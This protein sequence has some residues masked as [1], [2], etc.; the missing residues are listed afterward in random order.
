MLHSPDIYKL[1]DTQITA[2]D[3]VWE[4]SLLRALPTA[5]LK[6]INET[7]IIGPDGWPYL[8]VRA[9]SQ[10]GD[11]EI[12]TKI[13]SWLSERGIGLVLNP[14]KNTPDY[15]LTYGMIW[16]YRERGE[17]LSSQGVSL[18]NDQNSKKNDALI[19]N[20][21]DKI[22]SGAP[23]TEYLPEYVRAVLRNFFK[24]NGSPDMKVLVMSEPS[25]TRDG[26][27]KNSD[28]SLYCLCFSLEAMGQPETTEHQGVLEAISWFLPSHYSIALMSEK[29]LPK[30]YNL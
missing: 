9:D 26:D 8:M 12:A 18:S 1:I 19:F 13:F 27:L 17:F 3:V 23:S 28:S 30:F 10:S 20:P 7:P 22:H 4:S 11:G 2:R 5:Q 6:V 25:K 24:D 14:Q 21:G 29:D 16:N 15:V